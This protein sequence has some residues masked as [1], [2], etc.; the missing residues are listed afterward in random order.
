MPNPI[1]SASYA[2][3]LK[4]PAA[5][6][7]HDRRPGQSRRAAKEGSQKGKDFLKTNS[8]ELPPCLLS[9]QRNIPKS[10]RLSFTFFLEGMGAKKPFHRNGLSLTSFREGRAESWGHDRVQKTTWCFLGCCRS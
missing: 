3:I 4:S 6:A 8:K 1:K 10:I 7:D 2:P 5:K 9:S